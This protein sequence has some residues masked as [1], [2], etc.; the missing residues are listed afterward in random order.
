MCLIQGEPRG[1]AA[2]RYADTVAGGTQ[3]TQSL[4]T[5]PP[6]GAEGGES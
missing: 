2:C 1:K 6:G 3:A 5:Q 4:L